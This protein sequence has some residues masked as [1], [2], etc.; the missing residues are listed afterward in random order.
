LREGDWGE[1]NAVMEEARARKAVVR[2]AYCIF[3]R[4]KI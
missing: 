1:G 2:R 4:L 3:E